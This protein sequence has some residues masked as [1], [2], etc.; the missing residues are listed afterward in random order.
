MNTFQYYKSLALPT[1]TLEEELNLGRAIASAKPK[2]K[3][4]DLRFELIRHN[5][6][7]M[8][9]VVSRFLTTNDSHE[10]DMFAEGY[11]VME[12]LSHK[13]DYR[14]QA[15][16]SSALFLPIKRAMLNYIK[17]MKACLKVPEILPL[18]AVNNLRRVQIADAQNDDVDKPVLILPCKV[19]LF[20][21]IHGHEMSALAAP[22]EAKLKATR[23]GRI[24]LDWHNDVPVQDIMKTHDLSRSAI[25]LILEA[26]KRTTNT[27]FQ[28]VFNELFH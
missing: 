11:L 12:K 25:Y 23:R 15:R 26:A 28:S 24:F 20:D 14:R 21:T 13:F 16:F 3:K 1:L 27:Q 22:I 18:N 6:M 17:K 7:Y 5:L 10:D 2:H 4:D 9:T 8:A 19:D